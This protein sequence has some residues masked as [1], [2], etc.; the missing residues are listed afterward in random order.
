MR[1]GKAGILILFPNGPLSV[2]RVLPPPPNSASQ[3][4][5]LSIGKF[6]SDCQPSTLMIVLTSFPLG[7]RG[8]LKDRKSVV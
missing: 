3:S 7:N 5:L 1:Q 6:G 8:R 2:S 4:S